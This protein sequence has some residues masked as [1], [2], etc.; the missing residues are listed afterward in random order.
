MKKASRN[1]LYVRNYIL[2]H[3]EG[4]ICDSLI[5]DGE[6]QHVII[7]PE[8]MEP[9]NL[10]IPPGWYWDEELRVLTNE[11]NIKGKPNKIFVFY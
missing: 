4:T 6:K 11:K 3:N 5:Y 1:P 8:G 2:K 9:K 10:I 7:L